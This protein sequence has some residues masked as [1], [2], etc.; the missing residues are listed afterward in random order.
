MFINGKI[1]NKPGAIL[2]SF[3]PNPQ[4]PY[5]IAKVA[6][7]NILKNLCEVHGVEYVITRSTQYYWTKTE[8]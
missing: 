7:E 1:W 5:G 2:E 4:D 3:T 6:A 8:I